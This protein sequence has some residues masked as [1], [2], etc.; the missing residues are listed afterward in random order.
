MRP[1]LLLTPV[2][3]SFQ[4]LESK[5][6]VDSVIEPIDLTGKVASESEFAKHGG[7]YADIYIGQCTTKDEM[8]SKVAIKVIRA[9]IYKDADRDKLQKV[10]KLCIPN[11][12]GR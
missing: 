10:I 7:S 4:N 11:T 5:P 8:P 3:C 9:H 12:R 1:D 6:I 2:N